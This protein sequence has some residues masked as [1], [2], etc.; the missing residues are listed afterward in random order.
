M[1]HAR[2]GMGG[3]RHLLRG[4]PVRLVARVQPA[5][6]SSPARPRAPPRGR[7]PVAR[8]RECLRPARAKDHGLTIYSSQIDRLFGGGGEMAKAVRTFATKVAALGG[9]EG[10]AAERYWATTRI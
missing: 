3:Y 7:V 5:R 1:G 2:A 9:L 4:F 8:V 10:A 6:G